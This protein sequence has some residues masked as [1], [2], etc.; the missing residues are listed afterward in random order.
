MQRVRSNRDP[1]DEERI[2][3]IASESKDGGVDVVR[4]AVRA[5]DGRRRGPGAAG[6]ARSAIPS[7]PVGLTFADVLQASLGG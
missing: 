7:V 3:R 2:A 4:A 1:V 6:E 5:A